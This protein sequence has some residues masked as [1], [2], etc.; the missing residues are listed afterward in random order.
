LSVPAA[1][2]LAKLAREAGKQA[3]VLQPVPDGADVRKWMNRCWNEWRTTAP[4]MSASALPAAASHYAAG[5]SSVIGSAWHDTVLLPTNKSVG[6]VLTVMNEEKTLPTIMAELRRMPLD[7]CVIVING[8]SDASFPIARES[9]NAVIVHYDQPLG[10]D[11]GRA[12]GA[13]LANAE[14]IVFLDGDMPVHAEQ[15]IPFIEAID[16]GTDVALN[17]ITPYLGIFAHRDSVSVMKEFLNRSLGRPDLAANSMTAIPHA[18]SRQALQMIGCT[19]LAVPPVAHA[20][21]IRG[22]LKVSAP[23]SIDVISG[24]RQRLNNAGLHN[25]VAGLIIGDHVEALARL[26]MLSGSRLLIPDQMRDRR[27]AGGG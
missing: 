12:M 10:H 13:K 6:I 24:N 1:S 21:A 25:E 20:L 5:F 23:A 7:E 3:A 19:Q 26:T 18:L 8:S 14:I 9:P 17:N 4:W 11:V 27:A 2:K 16:Q 15:L 22:G